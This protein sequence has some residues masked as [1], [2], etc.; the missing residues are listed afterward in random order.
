[1]Y[2]SWLASW[3]PFRIDALGLVTLL[4]AEQVN[5][6]LGCLT[7]NPITDYLPLLAAFVVT[8]DSFAEPIPG[9][10]LYN[11]SDGIIAYDVSP[12]FSRWLLMQNLTW[13]STCL[14]L[15][16]VSAS[17]GIAAWLLPLVIGVMA[18]GS[19]NVVT[20]L[21]GDWW[22]LANAI[23]LALSVCVRK[24]LLQ[25]RAQGLRNNWNLQSNEDWATTEVK[26]LVL[27]PA[28]HAITIFAPRGII[29]EVV[30]TEPKLRQKTAYT[31]T[32][33]LG[34]TAFGCHVICLGMASL[35]NQILAVSTLIA[36]TWLTG[37]GV[38]TDYS[39]VAGSLAIERYDG[40]V[41]SET[42]SRV[43]KRMQLTQ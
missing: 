19:I 1:M 24:V 14:R 41:L 21:M 32:R 37:Q 18:V 11:I 26:C 7:S 39:R 27:T 36:S 6:A 10:R 35:L 29:T 22:G 12:W 2:L 5:R 20:V 15:H 40:D 31:V 38:G 43:Y 28:G 4:G 33:M 9:F 25:A 30:L 3:Q 34:W 16:F 13:N 8:S 23:A 17:Q 42:R